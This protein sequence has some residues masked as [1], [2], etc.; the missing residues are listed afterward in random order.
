[1]AKTQGQ[2]TWENS[3]LKRLKQTTTVTI[4]Y[5]SHKNHP[6]T[7]PKQL[8]FSRTAHYSPE[9]SETPLFKGIPQFLSSDPSGFAFPS[10]RE[11]PW[12]KRQAL[13]K[14]LATRFSDF[15]LGHSFF[16]RAKLVNCHDLIVE[17]QCVSVSIRRTSIY[18]YLIIIYSN[19]AKILS[20]WPRICLPRVT[21]TA[22]Y[23]Q[24]SCFHFPFFFFLCI[25]RGS[26][27]VIRLPRAVYVH[28]V[29]NWWKW[30]QIMTLKIG[31]RHTHTHTYIYIH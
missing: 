9:I 21:Y 15:P 30:N 11:P 13:P 18:G 1:M 16:S 12:A 4:W 28:R 3:S 2:T 5:H 31:P 23:L 20:F 17:V 25:Q 24:N 14:H 26:Q 8:I 19:L 10:V 27:T 22:F 6:A 7:R 29:I